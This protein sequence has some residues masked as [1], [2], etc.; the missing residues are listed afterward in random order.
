MR[1]GDEAHP[2][3]LIEEHRQSLE[4]ERDDMK[5]AAE[6]ET[7][8]GSMP[9]TNKEWL[10][11]LEAN[12]EQLRDLLKH[13]GNARKRINERVI[14]LGEL[15]EAAR[16][17]P[18]PNAIDVT[19]KP[20]TLKKLASIANGFVSLQN[21]LLFLCTLNRDCWSLPTQRG[22]GRS[23]HFATTDLR[24]RYKP[25]LEV[26]ESMGVDLCDDSSRVYILRT[27]WV[28]E[29][30]GVVH[31]HIE[32]WYEWELPLRKTTSKRQRC[33]S[34]SKAVD[35]ATDSDDADDQDDLHAVSGSDV[36]SLCSSAES[37]AEAAAEDV[38]VE[39]SDCEYQVDGGE[40][41]GVDAGQPSGAGDA[42]DLAVADM[43]DGQVADRADAGVSNV[44]HLC[45]GYFTVTDNPNF[46]NLKVIVKK[47]WVADMGSG[48][49]SRTLTPQHYDE[50]KGGSVPLTHCLLQTWMVQRFRA[51][52]FALAKHSRQAW[53]SHLLNQ[54]R[55]ALQL[56]AG[57][58]MQS[59]GNAKADA[60][61]REWAPGI[62]V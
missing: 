55:R 33:S 54:L 42:L 53:L 62:L 32:S 51:T 52:N 3:A 36:A 47:R 23:I 25:M 27:R 58:A 49:M 29:D 46:S 6:A 9:F 61:M 21:Q 40:A 20:S 10:S 14:L 59:T 19:S 13:G 8:E 18:K 37:A 48:T 56:V 31:L 12:D 41:L 43:E 60:L 16:V 22:S 2:K 57:P 39:G 26:A 24:D 35:V 34:S 44:Q 11:Y 15:T 5:A 28:G 7:C 4:K 1:P 50:V 17:D 38:D 30:G 45:N